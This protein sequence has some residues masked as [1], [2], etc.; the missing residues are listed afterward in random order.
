[1]G[2]A[3]A[4]AVIY[5]ATVDIDRRLLPH[6]LFAILAIA[7]AMSARTERG[8]MHS[9]TAAEVRGASLRRRAL[10]GS[11][12]GRLRENDAW[13]AATALSAAFHRSVDV[14]RLGF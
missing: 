1:M 13:I 7:N 10:Q 11:L 14:S 2:T 8:M 5:A 3:A 9:V 12:T 6:L 4:Q